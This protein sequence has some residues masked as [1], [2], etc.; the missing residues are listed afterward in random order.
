MLSINCYIRAKVSQIVQR[1]DDVV[2]D[3]K[4]IYPILLWHFG[5]SQVELIDT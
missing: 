2:V 4:A 3:E 1:D 5:Y